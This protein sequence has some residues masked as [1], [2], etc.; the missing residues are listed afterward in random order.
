MEFTL[1]LKMLNSDLMSLKHESVEEKVKNF[2][3]DAEKKK[4]DG[5]DDSNDRARE[6]WTFTQLIFLP[7]PLRGEGEYTT[8]S[9]RCDA[10]HQRN[11]QEQ[12]SDKQEIQCFPHLTTYYVCSLLKKKTKNRNSISEKKI[13]KKK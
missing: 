8:H 10:K 11:L 13:W 2:S 6:H 7:V 12:V 9:A 3:Q 5:N 1:K 4:V